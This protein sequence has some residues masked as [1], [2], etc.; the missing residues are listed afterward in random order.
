MK[1]RVCLILV[2]ALTVSVICPELRAWNSTGHKTIASMIFRRLSAD[3]RME[4]AELLTSHPRYQEDFLNEMPE[5]VRDAD[6]QTRAEWLL[7]QASIWPDIVRD[8]SPGRAEYHR[9]FWHYL[10]RAFYLTPPTDEFRQQVESGFNGALEPVG[11]TQNLDLNGP[12]AFK[13]NYRALNDTNAPPGDRAVALCWVL[14]IGQDLHQP[15]HTASLC[16][17]QRFPEGDQGGNSIRTRPLRNLH[18]VWD[19]P[20]GPGDRYESCRDLAIVM[21]GDAPEDLLN[22]NVTGISEQMNLWLAEG[23]TL[24]GDSVYI[25]EVREALIL[26]NERTTI[27]LSPTYLRNVRTAANGRLLNAAVRL[28]ELL[29]RRSP[30]DGSET[31]R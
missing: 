27:N 1:L 15:C 31:P 25:D 6:P 2:L 14:H 8:E 17:P 11:G 5:R 28:G 22:Q 20:L 30:T 16:S 13:A 29:E 18:A 3:R 9:P 24:L 19:S 26:D 21:L 4:L 12:Q 7:Q 10:P 23:L